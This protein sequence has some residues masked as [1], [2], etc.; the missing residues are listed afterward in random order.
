MSPLR[1]WDRF[2]FGPVSARPLGMFRVA[3]GLIALE[4]LALLA[5][6]LDH[7]LTDAGLLVGADAR[8][9]AGPLRPSSVRT[10]SRASSSTP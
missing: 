5:A 8:L 7:W 6:D 4:H 9:L 1:A 10:G 3:F 2:W